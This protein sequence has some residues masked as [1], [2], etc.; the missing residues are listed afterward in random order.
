MSKTTFFS[1]IKGNI[2]CAF[3][4]RKNCPLRYYPNHKK[5][6]GGSIIGCNKDFEKRSKKSLKRKLP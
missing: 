6:V 3:C 2:E 1:V 5:I 4:K